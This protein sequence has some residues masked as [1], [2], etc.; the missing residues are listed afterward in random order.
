MVRRFAKHAMEFRFAKSSDIYEIDTLRKSCGGLEF[1]FDASIP[2]EKL[3]ELGV[4]TT[5]AVNESGSILG[6]VS[7]ATSFPGISFA[8]I[9]SSVNDIVEGGGLYAGNVAS[10]TCLSVSPSADLPNELT[11]ELLEHAM[12]P[13]HDTEHL[14]ILSPPS[15]GLGDYSEELESSLLGPLGCV[16]TP[17]E[18]DGCMAL[19][20][21]PSPLRPLLVREAA[22]EDF[23]DLQAIF[24]S[25]SE[26]VKS[27][28]GEY[29]LAEVIEAAEHDPS[30]KVLVGVRNGRAVGLLAVTASIPVKIMQDNF[31]TECVNNLVRPSPDMVTETQRLSSFQ[32]RHRSDWLAVLESNIQEIPGLITT[33]QR[34]PIPEGTLSAPGN[35]SWFG[36][37][38]GGAFEG[39]LI[40]DLLD[41]LN[42]MGD[43]WGYGG[44]CETKMGTMMLVDLGK[45]AP[46]GR[47]AEQQD[48]VIHLGAL[49]E[50][51]TEHARRR[52]SSALLARIT[53]WYSPPD[54]PR[55]GYSMLMGAWER[56]TACLDVDR[57]ER[58]KTLQLETSAAIKFAEMAALSERNVCEAA[59]KEAYEKER[60]DVKPSKGQK[61][62]NVA[63]LPVPGTPAVIAAREARAAA[64]AR[65]EACVKAMETAQSELSNPLLISLEDL[66]HFISRNSKEGG[67][68][69]VVCG[70]CPTDDFLAEFSSQSKLELSSLDLSSL[71]EVW[72][73]TRLSRCLH[74]VVFVTSTKGEG[75]PICVPPPGTLHTQDA[76]EAALASAAGKLLGAPVLFLPNLMTAAAKA[77]STASADLA[78][79]QSKYAV[80]EEKRKKLEDEA[81]AAKEKGGPPPPKAAAPLLP[82]SPT[83]QQAASRL[84]KF[85]DAFTD[86]LSALVAYIKSGDIDVSK[87]MVL[88]GI[89]VYD[90]SACQRLSEAL[91]QAGHPPTLHLHA[92]TRAVSPTRQSKEEVFLGGTARKRRESL[93]PPP[94]DR[95]S[96]APC[97]GLLGD[98]VRRVCAES[99][100]LINKRA[101][102]LVSGPNSVDLSG[103]T[104]EELIREDVE[105]VLLEQSL[106]LVAKD[107]LAPPLCPPSP[108]PDSATAV[109]N[110]FCMRH[111]CEARISDL[112]HAVFSEF[113]SMSFIAL[114]QPFTSPYGEATLSKFLQIPNRD[115]STLNSTLYV[116]PR[117]ALHCPR[118]LVVRRAKTTDRQQLYALCSRNPGGGGERD[119][120]A[121]V[122]AS[123]AREHIPLFPTPPRVATFVAEIKGKI[124]GAIVVG[125]VGCSPAS[126]KATALSFKLEE[127][128]DGFSFQGKEGVA[129]LLFSYLDFP[130]LN[131][132]P[133]FHRECLAL[134]GCKTSLLY[135]LPPLSPSSTHIAGFL[136]QSIFNAFRFVSPRHLPELPPSD[137]AKVAAVPQPNVDSSLPF[138]S[139][140]VSL[141]PFFVAQGLCESDLADQRSHAHA[142]YIFTPFLSTHRRTVRNERILV[143]GNSDTVVGFLVSLIDHANPLLPHVSVLCGETGLA[144]PC[145]PFSSPAP[146]SIGREFSSFQLSR[147]PIT[148]HFSFIQS[149]IVSIERGSNQVSIGGGGKIKYD[150]L[151]LLPELKEPTKFRLDVVSRHPPKGC[152]FMDCTLN[153]A[154]LEEMVALTAH[155]LSS[156]DATQG[157]HDSLAN[158]NHPEAHH[159]G[160]HRHSPQPPHSH[161][162]LVYGNTVQAVETLAGLL[163]R[164]VP[165]DFIVL[166]LPPTAQSAPNISQELVDMGVAAAGLDGKTE[167]KIWAGDLMSG[168]LPMKSPSPHALFPALTVSRVLSSSGVRVVRGATI[169]EIS[170]HGDELMVGIELQ[171]QAGHVFQ[172]NVQASLLLCADTPDVDPGFFAACNNSSLV[173]DQFLVLDHNFRTMDDKIYGGGPATKF[174]RKLGHPVPLLAH[175]K[176]EVGT[177][178]GKSVLL[179]LEVQHSHDHDND[180]E[181]ELDHMDEVIRDRA[182]QKI[183]ESAPVAALPQNF[184]K[185]RIVRCMLPGGFIFFWATLAHY[186]MGGSGKEVVTHF[187]SD[188]GD[189][190]H[191]SVF[192]LFSL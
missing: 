16:R 73:R 137:Q 60:G 141:S 115:T 27:S 61:P 129:S 35:G 72:E 151:V 148:A 105:G 5:V 158:P 22:V 100:S 64:E 45:L 110:M 164:G 144:T 9:I 143:Q 192:F 155:M 53:S 128:M 178:V 51:L 149:D 77:H 50:S 34:V 107:S 26:V 111:D 183:V 28:F 184:I 187:L 76:G 30:K 167:H 86:P 17:I 146:F 103:F 40:T 87:G 180:I 13:L 23:D 116:C 121:A 190:R 174:S 43:A 150:R 91:L 36:N 48:C 126:L 168:L 102:F 81:A 66:L 154:A 185:P 79:A 38:C 2:T 139:D 122:V 120:M 147:L 145:E 170:E 163:D 124:V 104:L 127:C 94:L 108:T 71:L 165:A 84:A 68:A 106:T 10:L 89:P 67:G 109:V 131:S 117:E 189:F 140:P 172:W 78:D 20:L 37:I 157:Q 62:V 54:A 74:P 49:E 93:A 6:F 161:S 41:L 166:L 142:L 39:V 55:R 191:T 162:V 4:S 56:A 169:S 182:L 12:K 57:K 19:Y 135:R 58:L 186:E 133:Y 171:S 24:E 80:Y 159:R 18:V 85:S 52:A 75:F 152:F 46:W 65:S 3:I 188:N 15:S 136:P 95:L 8:D 177:L 21:L 153:E 14:I 98:V 99:T 25:Q 29:Y 101:S 134:Y 32:A 70:D 173:F 179:G 31:H 90:S 181:Y 97:S 175:S 59:A 42:T 113:P 112:L 47:G 92:E 33:L 123:E 125:S 82:P 83:P 88:S 96:E 11:A 132:S 156:L 119:F 176:A 44:P 69:S 130:F 7:L 114:T 1:L 63:T 118:D 160:H 138:Q